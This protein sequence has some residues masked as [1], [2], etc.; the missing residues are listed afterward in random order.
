MEFGPRQNS[1][2]RTHPL[3]DAGTMAGRSCS[4]LRRDFS[5]DALSF[6]RPNLNCRS[7]APGVAA[8]SMMRPAMSFM[9]E[10]GWSGWQYLSNWEDRASQSCVF[11]LPCPYFVDV[12]TQRFATFF[13]F[14]WSTHE[15][16]TPRDPC[17]AVA[18][19]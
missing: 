9:S 7:A 1:M 18:D 4:G 2:G 10:P 11:E 3:F 6:S 16:S 15:D 5:Q 8:P 14:W 19:C 17:F 12:P 13:L